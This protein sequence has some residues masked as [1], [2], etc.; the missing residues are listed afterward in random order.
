MV[1]LRYVAIKEKDV[2]NFKD[3]TKD[4]LKEN[5]P[6]KEIPTPVYH[7]RYYFWRKRGFD[8]G[9]ITDSCCDVGNKKMVGARKVVWEER[10]NAPS[11]FQE[12]LTFLSCYI[13]NEYFRLLSLITLLFMYKILGTSSIILN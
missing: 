10:L 1:Y 13:K 6:K 5:I 3:L 12:N 8:E 7:P 9:N 4:Y 2:C 11:S